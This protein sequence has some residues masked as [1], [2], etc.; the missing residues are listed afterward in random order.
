MT[1]L[2][3]LLAAHTDTGPLRW[4]N[5]PPPWLLTVLVVVGFFWIRSLYTQERGRAGPLA[6]HGLAVQLE[7]ALVLVGEVHQVRHR[8]LHAV[9]HLVLLEART[10]LGVEHSLVLALR[11]LA[12]QVQDPAPIGPRDPRRVVQVQHR[13][14]ARAQL[15]ALVL[16]GQEAGAPEAEIE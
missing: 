9:R 14:G 6:R 13:V 3:G 12:D 2:A 15:A 16:A 7:R 5:L 10:D 8:H 4:A 11:E 1:S